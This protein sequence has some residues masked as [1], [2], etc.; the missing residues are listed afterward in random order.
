MSQTT[1]AFYIDE[2][3]HRAITVGLRM[4]GVDVLADAEELKN[5][6]QYLPL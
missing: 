2:N 5:R 1:I 6:I 3:V 4:R